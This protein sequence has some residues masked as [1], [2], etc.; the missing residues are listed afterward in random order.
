MI[1]T[2][3]LNYL[4]TAELSAD[5]YMEQPKVKPAAFFLLEKTGGSLTDHVYESSFIVQS[6]GKTLADAA[7]MNEEIKSAML[8]AITLEDISRV[9]LNSDYNYTD[10]TTK[11][12]R[13]QA[14]F[15]VTHY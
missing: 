9:E 10:P 15:V 8:N 12:Y 6:Y 5:I 4:K 3:L 1:E 2:I 14:V 11:N 13:Y 7:N